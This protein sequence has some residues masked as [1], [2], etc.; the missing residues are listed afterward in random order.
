[1]QTTNRTELGAFFLLRNKGHKML[2]AF[3]NTVHVRIYAILNWK[4]KMVT[5]CFF[6]LRTAALIMHSFIHQATQHLDNNAHRPQPRQLHIIIIRLNNF[7]HIRAVNV[8]SCV[9]V[10]TVL[11]CISSF[12]NDSDPI[13]EKNKNKIDGLV[14]DIGRCMFSS[15]PKWIWN[16][17]K[18]G[19]YLIWSSLN[20]L[21]QS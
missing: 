3:L 12:L 1:M 13:E 8:I 14:A 15:E 9:R 10:H 4:M 19:N 20:I 18:R 16:C 17:I 6:F 11:L 2:G 21:D 5:L 7:I